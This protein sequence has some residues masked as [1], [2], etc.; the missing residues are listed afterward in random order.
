MCSWEVGHQLV[1]KGRHVV[2]TVREPVLTSAKTKPWRGDTNYRD[3]SCRPFG[4]QTVFLSC[5][6]GLAPMATSCRH[7]V[8]VETGASAQMAQGSDVWRVQLPVCGKSLRWR[9]RI[10]GLFLSL[11][12]RHDSPIFFADVPTQNGPENRQRRDDP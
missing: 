11:V 9:F 4:T 3:S 7:F 5:F 12:A 10:L 6:H 1:P 8:A 2:A